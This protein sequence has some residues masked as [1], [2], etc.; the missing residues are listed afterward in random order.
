[1]SKKCEATLR[2]TEPV[3]LV[4]S[5]SKLNLKYELN[6]NAEYVCIPHSMKRL[7]PLITMFLYHYEPSVEEMKELR[8]S[9]R[10]EINSGPGAGSEIT[11]Q[12]LQELDSGK[13]PR[14]WLDDWTRVPLFGSEIWAKEMS[15]PQ[16]HSVGKIE[17]EPDQPFT[18]ELSVNVPSIPGMGGLGKDFFVVFMA[19]FMFKPK[20]VPWKRIYANAAAAVILPVNGSDRDSTLL[21]E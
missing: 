21:S 5:G 8:R 4:K 3:D 15:R 18:K 13:D 20:G 6:T 9:A 12:K 16:M 19:T 11:R 2:S 7:E 14:H 17:L 10:T 1:M